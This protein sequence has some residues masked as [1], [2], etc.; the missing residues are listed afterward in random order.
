MRHHPALALAA[1]L[2]APVVA[3]GSA[4]IAAMEAPAA[5]A[6]T[7]APSDCPLHAQHM[8][9]AAGGD[10]H[11]HDSDLKARG[12][13][14]M[15][16]SQEATTHHF[17]LAADG[18]AVEVTAND[19]ADEPT[20]A[21]VRQHLRHIAAAFAAGDFAIPEAVHG[22]P[23]PGSA[24][25][26]AAGEGIAYGYSDLPAGG[27]VRI[28]ARNDAALAAVHEFLRFQ[29]ADHGTGDPTSVPAP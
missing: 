24:A 5:P 19:P 29:I 21:R 26:D 20:I 3:P 18:G 12:D 10:A 7:Q 13:R 4:A 8:A 9:A 27:R 6:A 28:T 11:S 16:F 1:A 17:V 14:H 23:P 22:Q 2:L 15:G 25:M